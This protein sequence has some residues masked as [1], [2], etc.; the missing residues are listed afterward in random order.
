MVSTEATSGISVSQE[1]QGSELACLVAS[2][3]FNLELDSVDKEL[4]ERVANPQRESTRKVYSGKWGV[5]QSWCKQNKVVCT[6][7]SSKDLG[8]FFL[9][10]FKEKG[11]LPVTIQG[12]RSALSNHLYGKVQWDIARDPSLNR[13]MESFFRDKPVIDRRI[14]PWDLRVVL[15]SLTKAPFEPL[16]L[17]P[18]KF[19]TLKTV[20]LVTLASGKRCSE[21]HSLLHARL[22]RD[23]TWSYVSLEPSSRFMAKNQVA[24]HGTSV[25]QPIIIPALAPTLSGELKDDKLLCPVRALRYYLDHTKDLRGD[26][27]LLFISHWK[28]HKADIKKKTISSWLIQ[29]IRLALQSCSE[30]TAK[31]C[32]VRAHDI[33]ALAASYAF[34]SGV[35]LEE[36]MKACSWRAHNTFTS[37]YLKD[38]ALTNPEGKISLGPIITAQKVTSCDLSGR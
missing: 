22:R 26:R 25:L 9:F 13:L 21:I 8:R 29:T 35:A 32:N 12:Y 3:G 5:F 38:L 17:A 19:V 18:L 20:F 24:K 4:E 31:L 6:D 10:L 33:R 36:V 28:G 27:E 7:P 37:H 15:Q 1:P 30:E 23:A 11:L 34:R 14:P 16:A 2:R